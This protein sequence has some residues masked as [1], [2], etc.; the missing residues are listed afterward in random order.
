MHILLLA[1]LLVA[2]A[3][4]HVGDR[5]Y[6]IPEITDQ[7]LDRFDLHDMN[8]DDWHGILQEPALWATDFVSDPT[9]GKGAPYDP[10]DLDYQIW[11]GWNG[12]TNRLYFALERTDDTF[13]NEYE[14]GA[15]GN[16]W[17]HDGSFELLLDGDHSGGD[18]TGSADPDWTDEEKTLNNN[19][20]AQQYFGI[21]DAPDDY[22][23]GYQG[24]ARSWVCALPYA[25]TG[26]STTGENPSIS[27]FEGFVT[28]FDD[29]IWNSPEVSEPSRLFSGKIIGFNIEIPDFDTEPMAY[30]AYHALSG[31]PAWRYAET[32]VDARLISGP[33]NTAVESRSWALI[34]AAFK[35][36]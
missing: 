34:K 9:V 17:R 19:R 26:G 1:L 31:K 16:F 30:R 28:P 25:D 22:H 35:G 32:F 24:A 33:D 12:S 4:A 11:L 2:P 20:T 10:G 13:V 14:G 3:K 15:P 5:I 27:I 7:D 21:A 18:Y 6:P 36:E 8:L 23:L 29:L